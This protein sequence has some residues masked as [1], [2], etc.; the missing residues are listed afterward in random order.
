MMSIGAALI[1]SAG[2]FVANRQN[3]KQASKQTAFQREM[4]DTSY[5]RA[6]KDMR[7]AGLNP[8][9]AGKMGGASTPAGAMANIGNVGQAGLQGYGVA[10][11]AKQ[12]QASAQKIR[13]E[14]KQVVQTTGFQETVHKERWSKLFAGMGPDNVL[15]SVFASLSGVDVQGVLQGRAITANT[16]KNLEDFVRYVQSNKNFITTTTS[17]LDELG[18]RFGEMFNIWEKS[19]K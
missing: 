16:R 19:V 14:A 4:S 15:A 18:R 9:L 13:E 1:A 10:S 6:V 17:S 12:S 3:Q 11:S 5:Q 7:A 2:Q 8:I